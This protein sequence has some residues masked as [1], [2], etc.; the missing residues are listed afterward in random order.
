MPL[1]CSLMIHVLFSRVDKVGKRTL[2][3]CSLMIHVLFS[4]VDKVG[5]R[6]GALT[7]FLFQM[8]RYYCDTMAP[9]CPLEIKS[10]FDALS[11]KEKK[12]AHYIAKAAWEGLPTLTHTLSPESPALYNLV[13][14]L[15]SNAFEPKDY[16]ALKTM[17]GVSQRDWDWF[18]EYCMQ[19]LALI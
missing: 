6:K 19:V 5:K 7:P 13:M 17:A 3:F 18:V 14:L 11:E 15:F 1:C 2:L 10:H 9:I 12:Y 8:Q 4:R 16:S